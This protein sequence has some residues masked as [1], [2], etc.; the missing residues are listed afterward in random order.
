MKTRKSLSIILALCLLMSLVSVCFVGSVSAATIDAATA[1]NNADDVASSIR[2]EGVRPD[3]SYMSAGLRFRGSV[4]AATK[5]AAAEIGF[6]VAPAK[7]AVAYGA[8]WYKA[9]GEL[10][11]GIGALSAACYNAA[12][13]MD[14]VYSE[15][16]DGDCAYQMIL[17][18]LSREDGKT[19]YKHRFVAVM[20]VEKA[21]G[22]RDYYNLG[23]ISY[24]E[25][26][27]AYGI[28]GHQIPAN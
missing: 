4:S 12:S 26:K 22:T 15:D 1:P 8:E 21:D 20:Y 23:E 11:D 17:T 3:G 24:N 6:I 28:M 13:G 19:A 2:G 14:V 7:A 25:V 10:T 9:D 5:A 16:T 27:T 18:G